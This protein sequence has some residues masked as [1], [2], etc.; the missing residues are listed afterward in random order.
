MLVAREQAGKYNIVTQTC[1]P[2]NKCHNPTHTHCLFSTISYDMTWE[3]LHRLIAEMDAEDWTWA[4]DNF[5]VHH[6]IKHEHEDC[7]Y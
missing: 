7:G 5:K 2:L 3:Y 1:D 6:H 4:F